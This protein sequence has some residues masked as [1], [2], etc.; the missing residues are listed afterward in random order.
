MTF[1]VILPFV[2]SGITALGMHVIG[3]K[4]KRGWLIGL[5]NQVLWVVFI[6]YTE[7]WGLFILTAILTKIYLTNYLKWRMEEEL[8]RQEAQLRHERGLLDESK[9]NEGD[10][11]NWGVYEDECA[12]CH[13]RVLVVSTVHSVAEGYSEW[14]NGPHL[15]EECGWDTN[16]P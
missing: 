5:G 10:G 13:K 11:L 1:W 2:L 6:V 9:V 14:H 4:D 15:C 12:L 7:S 8:D 3:S 16:K